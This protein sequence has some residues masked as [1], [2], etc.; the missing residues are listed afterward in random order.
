MA[1]AP[2][3]T[4]FIYIHLIPI[5]L[6]T[7]NIKYQN[8]PLRLSVF[9]LVL[10]KCPPIQH[11]RIFGI[12]ED[13]KHLWIVETLFW[14]NV[15]K[16]SWVSTDLYN[17]VIENVDIKCNGGNPIKFY[18]PLVQSTCLILDPP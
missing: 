14:Q 12:L 18:P 2:P 3:Q 17:Y 5:K 10:S 6:S 7:Q 13:R 4:I 1:P 16:S 8:I 9:I 11:S 15:K